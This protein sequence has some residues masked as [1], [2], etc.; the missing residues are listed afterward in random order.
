VDA[1]AEPIIAAIREAFADA[2]RG[3]ITIHEA[4]VIDSYGSEAEREEARKHDTE[5]HWSEV[6]D[7]EIEECAW[8]LP[9]LDPESWRYYV[10]AY[11][12]WSLR[13]FQ[14]NN[15]IVSDFTI[16]A[17]NLHDDSE[18]REYKLA[19]FRLLNPA[20]ARAVGLFLRYM[21]DHRDHADSETAARALAEYWGEFA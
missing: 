18:L 1:D 11:M 3:R 16:Y 20:Q 5:A 2:R 12:I 4:E 15:S 14:T 9:H 7:R 6:P 19:R 8:A 13:Y 10:P 17:F 21:A